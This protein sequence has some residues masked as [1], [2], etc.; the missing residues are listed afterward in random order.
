M[1][2]NKDTNHIVSKL[3]FR[4]PSRFSRRD[5]SRCECIHGVFVDAGPVAIANSLAKFIC[6]RLHQCSGAFPAWNG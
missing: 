6:E 1:P 2:G 4:P 3:L 5:H